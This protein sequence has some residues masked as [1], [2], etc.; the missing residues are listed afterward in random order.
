MDIN[1]IN[2]LKKFVQNGVDYSELERLTNRYDEQYESSISPFDI[3]INSARGNIIYRNDISYS[4]IVDYG[5]PLKKG[6]IS[7]R[8]SKL[9]REVL[10]KHEDNF[11]SG[12]IVE[13]EHKVSKETQTHL[14]LQNLETKDGYD[15]STM[16]FCNSTL[17]IPGDTTKTIVGYDGMGRP[18]YDEVTSPST[19]LSCI[20]ESK[21][22]MSPDQEPINLPNGRLIVIIPYTDNAK[23]KLN[24]KFDMYGNSYEVSHVDRSQVVGTVGIIELTADLVQGG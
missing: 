9:K 13:F 18:I 3:L 11:K 10:T 6:A 21:V 23:V 7:S 2:E 20:A 8:T 12:D 5:N 24:F 19:T 15:L 17:T 1:Q 4:C 22:Y 14:F 16:Q